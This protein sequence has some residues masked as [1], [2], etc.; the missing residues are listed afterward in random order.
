MRGGRRGSRSP[1][2]PLAMVLAATA[3]G[4]ASPS[5][6]G[7]GDLPG[8]VTGSAAFGV[9]SDGS[10]VVGQSFATSGLTAVRWEN[11]LLSSLPDLPGGETFGTAAAVNRDGTIVVGTSKGPIEFNEVVI[12]TNGVVTGYGDLPGGRYASTGTGISASGNVF[13][14][15]GESGSGTEGFRVVNGLMTGLGDISGGAFYSK[16][17]DV[18]ADGTIIVG[19]S[20]G[21]TP[22]YEAVRWVNGSLARLGKLP[23]GND[24]SNAEG[25]SADGT[26]IVGWSGSTAAGVG[27][28]YEAFRWQ[29][30]VMQGLGDLP[31]GVFA[32]EAYAASG[33][34]SVVV[35]RSRTDEGWEAFIWDAADGEMRRLQDVLVNEYNLNLT[36]WLLTRANDIS[37]DGLT[38]VGEG[39]NPNGESEG[40][41]ARLGD[42]SG[43]GDPLDCDVVLDPGLASGSNTF[44]RVRTLAQTFRPASSGVISAIIHG[45][46]TRGGLQSF[47]VYLTT[48]NRAGL[49]PEDFRTD[50]LWSASN[51][52][53]FSSGNPTV[54]GRIDLPGAEAVDVRAGVAYSLILEPAG[55]GSMSW[56]GVGDANAYGGGTALE[57]DPV[58]GAWT[59]P[60]TGPLDHTFRIIGCDG[61]VAILSGTCPGRVTLDIRNATPVSTLAIL[62]AVSTG[63][64]VIPGN[65]PCPGTVLDLGNGGL[66]LVGTVQTDA[67][68]SATF[69]GNAPAAACGGYVQVLDLNDCAT[70]N[71]VRVQ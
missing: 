45:L 63:S 54:D 69:S 49:P 24:Y 51:L 56:R 27:S 48:T 40:W 60:V 16:A 58:S 18:S 59:V 43:G 12:W 13:C 5:F 46:D 2:L 50:N 65:Q 21:V 31:G 20:R 57:R 4:H 36:G 41:I 26:V 32:S 30:N 70:S 17:N 68:G 52:T 64:A 11:G 38:I 23:G 22:E 29:N 37:D 42:S 66:R 14:G 19:I 39:F 55:S 8:G 25:I 67:S 71:V 9:S 6:Q 7:L 15:G 33:D 44:I 1:L 47:N 28:F 10:V 61:P 34:G 3:I 35:G 53:N 62:Y